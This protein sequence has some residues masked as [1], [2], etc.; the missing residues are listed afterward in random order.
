[1]LA[2]LAL[3]AV[4][5]GAA[6]ADATITVSGG[7]LSVTP[8]AITFQAVTLNGGDQT[9]NGTTSAWTIADPTG[10]GAGYHVTIA[11]TN[12][13]DGASHTIPVSGFRATLLD[14]NIVTTSG[15]TKPTS[16]MTSATALSTTAQTLVSAAAGAGMG[17]YTATPTFTLA[18]PANTFAG[19]YTSTVTVAIV[20]GP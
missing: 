8:A 1:M 15:N 12:F 7:S 2:A 11:A 18:V 3:A 9:S 4:P 5:L 16:S 10:T 20:S 14:A 17:T 6:L 13:T 19:S